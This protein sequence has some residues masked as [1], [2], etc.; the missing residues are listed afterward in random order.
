MA[1]SF[2]TSGSTSRPKPSKPWDCRSKTLTPTPESPSVESGFKAEAVKLGVA[3]VGATNRSIQRAGQGGHTTRTESLA[4]LQSCCPPRCERHDL[5]R[6]HRLS[7]G[8][9]L[10]DI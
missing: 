7:R 1:R 3:V 4:V 2:A 10:G 8:L 9:D 5:V 6:K